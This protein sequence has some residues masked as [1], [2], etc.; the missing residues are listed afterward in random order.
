MSNLK[1]VMRRNVEDI[2]Q[3]TG[4]IH[5]GL[6]APIK[7]CILYFRHEAHV[8]LKQDQRCQIRS[9]KRIILF[10]IHGFMWSE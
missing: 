10:V 2:F 5:S 7:F 6:K 4:T 3:R 8:M 1:R 9:N